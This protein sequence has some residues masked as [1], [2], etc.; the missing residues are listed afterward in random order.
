MKKNIIRIVSAFLCMLMIAGII[1]AVPATAYNKATYDDIKNSSTEELRKQL[2]ELGALLKETQDS[3]KEAEKLQAEA[4]E[5]REIYLTMQALYEDTLKYME[6]EL[7]LIEKEAEDI[8]TQ[9]AVT[10]VEYDRQYASFLDL[11]RM[12]SEEGEAN[13]IDILLNA[14]SLSDLLARIDRVSAMIKYSDHIMGSLTEKK[15]T[16]DESYAAS[17]KK[18]EEQNERITLYENKKAELAEWQREN[19]AAISVIENEIADLIAKSDTYTDRTDVLD[20]EFQQM[21][22]ELQAAENKKRAEAEEK[23]RQ[24][25]LAA[26]EKKRLEEEA[27]RLKAIQDA[28]KNQGFL[29]PLPASCLT[30]SSSFGN[31]MHPV[32]HKMQFHYGVDLPAPKGTAVYASKDGKVVAAKY[33]VS[34]G[35]YILIDHLDGTQTLYSH[36]DTGSML[37]SANDVVKRGQRIAGVGTTGVSTGYH[38]HFEVR[39]NGNCVD[40]LKYAVAPG[41]LYIYG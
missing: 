31:R 9:I 32:Y 25:A 26:A 13:Y 12:T 8:A 28:A 18:A 41:K 39:V 10:Q 17:L 1:P 22:T 23:A 7:V 19:E 34:Y 29:W 40:P 2:E 3:L 20:A 35:N 24:E 38:L 30:V 4:S 36:L 5:K 16:L 6:S 21:I 14:S 15:K 27:A 37:V 33:H 11:L